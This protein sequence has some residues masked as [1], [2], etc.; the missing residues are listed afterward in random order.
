MRFRAIHFSITYCRVELRYS[1]PSPCFV[2]ARYT[3]R[4]HRPRRQMRCLSSR[5]ILLPSPN[6]QRK[7]SQTFPP[8]S[9]EIPPPSN[10]TSTSTW[11]WTCR[12]FLRNFPL[13]SSP[14]FPLNLPGKSSIYTTMPLGLSTGMLTIG[15][16]MEL[17]AGCEAGL[18]GVRGRV[19]V[20]CVFPPSVRRICSALW[21]MA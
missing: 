19:R 16:A 11:T 7:I 4:S 12:N 21:P 20:E 2:I 15:C 1:P 5:K 10:S 14:N 17:R 3:A 18:S 8:H 13:P 9:P 6:F